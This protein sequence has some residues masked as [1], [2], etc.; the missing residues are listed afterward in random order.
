LVLRAAQ[1]A[2]TP[3]D[4]LDPR[5]SLGKLGKH[6]RTPAWRSSPRLRHAA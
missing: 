3:L 1:R 6:G 2:L 5:R 4:V